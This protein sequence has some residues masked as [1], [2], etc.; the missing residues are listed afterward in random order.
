M[1]NGMANA[2]TEKIVYC[3]DT[4]HLMMSCNMQQVHDIGKECF[5][6]VIGRYLF[7]IW[8]E[9]QAEIYITNNEQVIRSKRPMYFVETI[10]TDNGVLKSH[11]S[12]KYPMLNHK[13]QVIGVMGESTLM[14]TAYNDS[15]DLPSPLTAQENRCFHLLLKGYSPKTI[16]KFMNISPRT[17]EHHIANIRNKLGCR[18]VKELLVTYL[19]WAVSSVKPSL[20]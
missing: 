20:F 1:N 15:A 13:Q 16:S 18:N 11:I 4:N 12:Y 9:K 14:L 17:A 7:D 2:E 5:H 8:T 3:V 10:S 6:D 19:P